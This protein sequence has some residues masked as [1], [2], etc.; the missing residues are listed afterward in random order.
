MAVNQDNFI[1]YLKEDHRVSASRNFQLCSFLVGTEIREYLLPT[2]KALVPMKMYQLEIKIINNAKNY[3][4]SNLATEGLNIDSWE[5][6]D[7]RVIDKNLDGII[8][9]Y[10][11][12]RG[13]K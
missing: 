6:K 4:T 10:K 12:L 8:M 9:D 2:V 3:K 1:L 7:N 11:L 5:L 13:P